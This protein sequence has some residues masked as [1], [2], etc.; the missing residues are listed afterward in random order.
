VAAGVRVAVLGVGIAVFALGSAIYL[1]AARGGGPR[2]ALMLA[3]WSRMGVV[4]GYSRPA[5]E[6]VVLVVG[7][8]LGVRSVLER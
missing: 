6:L 2:D 1:A 7:V 3:P 8:A 4:I 5:L